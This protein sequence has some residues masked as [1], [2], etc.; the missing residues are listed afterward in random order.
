MLPSEV[1]GK[2]WLQLCIAGFGLNWQRDD[3]RHGWLHLKSWGK[4]IH[5]LLYSLWSFQKAKALWPWD[6][7]LR[8]LCQWFLSLSADQECQ[9]WEIALHVPFT[10]CWEHLSSA[11]LLPD[12]GSA[13]MA[14]VECQMSP[15]HRSWVGCLWPSVQRGKSGPWQ[16]LINSRSV[17]CHLQGRQPGEQGRAQGLESDLPEE[18]PWLTS[19]IGGE[20]TRHSWVPTSYL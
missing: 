18:M 12:V 1:Q 16:S 10:Q 2:K 5:S 20:R 14:G 3:N 9:V 4:C 8:T 13:D 6:S 11:P 15:G 17:T 7:P 19:H